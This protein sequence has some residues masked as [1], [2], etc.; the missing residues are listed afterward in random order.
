MYFFCYYWIVYWQLIWW[1][2]FRIFFEGADLQ[3]ESKKLII[4]QDEEYDLKVPL[5]VLQFND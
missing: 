1:V 2:I 3:S 4:T 5:L